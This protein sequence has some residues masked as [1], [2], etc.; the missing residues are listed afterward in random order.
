LIECAGESIAASP[1]TVFRKRQNARLT[2]LS[3]S[4]QELRSA[5]AIQLCYDGRFDTKSKIDR[6]VLHEQF[7]GTD[8]KSERVIKVKSFPRKISVNSEVLF[9]AIVESC[10]DLLK[11]VYSVMADTTALNTGKKSGVN[12]R[13]EQYFEDNFERGVPVLECLFHVNEIYFKHVIEEIEGK[14]KGPGVMQEGSL[15][16]RINDLVIMDSMHPILR[17]ELP[18]VPIT[19]MVKVQLKAK[20]EWFIQQKRS[21]KVELRDDQTCLLVLSCFLFMDI[22]AELQC[23][24]KYQQEATCH[25][26][27]ITTA[28]GYIRLFIFKCIYFSVDEQAKLLRILS[29]IVSVYVHSFMIIHLKP[30][31]CDD[32]FITLF[33]SDLLLSFEDIDQDIHKMVMKYYLKHAGN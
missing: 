29:Y 26:R 33:Q 9:N 12:K 19:A 15:R 18:V 10:G 30:K 7:S 22:P 31:I 11:N 4:I 2:A 14:S 5:N 1:S 16:N 23:F 8:K 21:K 20:L 3:T 17:S 32:P 25:S 28:S 27:W 13:L 24:L 6:S